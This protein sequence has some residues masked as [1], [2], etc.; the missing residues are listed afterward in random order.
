MCVCLCVHTHG[1]LCL[2]NTCV[3]GACGIQKGILDLL[4]LEFQMVVNNHVGAR[5]KT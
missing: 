2:C 3:P 1:M 5:N 4:L